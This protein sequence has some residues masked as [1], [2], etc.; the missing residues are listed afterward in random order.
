MNCHD[1]QSLIMGFIDDR[2]S[3]EEQLAFLDHIEHCPD[4][5]DELEVYYMITAG[6][7]LLDEEHAGTLDLKKNLRELVKERRQSL[8]ARRRR[9]SRRRGIRFSAVLALIIVLILGAGIFKVVDYEISSFED[10]RKAAIETMPERVRLFLEE[11]MGLSFPEKPE[12]EA[13]IP[14][15]EEQAAFEYN[16]A[17]CPAY[18]RP[19]D[20]MMDKINAM[21]E[22]SEHE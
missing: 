14:Y 17:M 16:H 21:G 1:A 19:E 15:S 12:D 13:V 5:Y 4:C 9:S 2:L 11:Q 3:D 20:P 22:E 7:K 8:T 18:A 10:F 6:L